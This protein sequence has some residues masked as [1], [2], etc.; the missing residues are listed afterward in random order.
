MESW[1]VSY[2]CVGGGLLLMFVRLWSLHRVCRARWRL[3]EA[4]KA[5][6]DSSGIRG[7]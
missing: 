4:G 7:A 5:R 1:W 6:P 3:M 2:G